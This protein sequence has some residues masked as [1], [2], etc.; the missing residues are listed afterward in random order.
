MRMKT[1]ILSS[2]A[3]MFVSI[4]IACADELQL[5]PMK[6]GLWE[7]HTQQV[8]QGKK[9]DISMKMCKSHEF[10]KSMQASMKTAGENMRKL[11]HCTDSVTRLS[12]NS[13]SSEMHCEKDGSVTKTTMS[14]QGDTSYHMEMHMTDSK[15]ET[16]M[17]IDD[18]YVGNCPADMKPGDAVTGDGKKMNLGTP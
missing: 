7:S 3:M 12:G 13:Y 9:Y 8:I 10:D 6:E 16:V 17:I 15:S 4:G 11:N 14:Y 1:E 5:P 2:F 18:K